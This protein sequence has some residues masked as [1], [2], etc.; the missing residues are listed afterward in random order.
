MTNVE[1][2]AAEVLMPW[3]FYNQKSHGSDQEK[4]TLEFTKEVMLE[5]PYLR[6]L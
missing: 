5:L 6:L 3:K 4:S 2:V 1:S